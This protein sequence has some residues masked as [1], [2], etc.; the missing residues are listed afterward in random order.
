MF[1]NVFDSFPQSSI[2]GFRHHAI[3]ALRNSGDA[4]VSEAAQ[5]RWHAELQFDS[6]A[7]LCFDSF[8]S[9]DWIRFDS[10]DSTFDFI[11][12]TLSIDL[13]HNICTHW[14]KQCVSINVVISIKKNTQ[15]KKESYVYKKKHEKIQIKINK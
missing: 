12:F 7:S 13:I 9:V 6:I 3:L 1:L 8:R 11:F 5:R 2:P 10:A 4:L 14:V 15:I